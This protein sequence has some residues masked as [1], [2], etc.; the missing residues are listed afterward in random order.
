MID[1]ALRSMQ[2]PLRRRILYSLLERDSEEGLTVPGDVHRDGEDEATNLELVHRHLPMLEDCGLIHWS[3]SVG[4][5]RQGPAF[6]DVRPLMES[7]R[8]QEDD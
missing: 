2:H 3:P 5:V 8:E 1:Q 6:D 4:C 7:V